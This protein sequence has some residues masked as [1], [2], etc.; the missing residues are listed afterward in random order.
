MS[1]R[2]KLGPVRRS[3]LA[4][5]VTVLVPAAAAAQVPDTLHEGVDSVFVT[6]DANPT[7]VDAAPPDRLPITPRQAFIRSMIVP[8][9]GQSTFESYFRGGVFFSGWAANGFM[10]FRNQVRLEE[11]RARFDLGVEQ[12]AEYL[13]L[14][15]PNPDSMRAVLD[16]V[17]G[18]L[19]A[20]I[21]ADGVTGGANELRKLVRAREQQREDWI[22]WSIFW[23]LASG[24]DGFVTAHLA[25]FPAD[26][27]VRPN[28][29][30][31]V[32]MELRM[33]LPVAWPPGRRQ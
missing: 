1:S 28:R 32:T 6:P 12:L 7:I 31:G 25:D 5:W 2:P 33:P 4:C 17:P 13:V 9:W 15:S 23:V 8:G 3:I 18:V 24:V 14:S 10:L 19:R 30:R 29:G 26:I 21:R 27:E 20:A 22:A 11:A 16:T